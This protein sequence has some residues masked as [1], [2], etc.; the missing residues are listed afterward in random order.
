M[1]RLL[2]SALLSLTASVADAQNVHTWHTIAANTGVW[3]ARLQ[4]INEGGRFVSRSGI[5]LNQFLVS[6][7][8]SVDYGFA[9][10]KGTDFDVSYSL[11]MTKEDKKSF[12]SKACVFIITA[13]KPADPDVRVESFHGAKC[14][15]HV[16]KGVGENFT[17]G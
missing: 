7:S 10:P 1:K 13:N 16:V 15:W 9:F 12:T 3:Q 4:M 8:H 6:P 17:V 11:T 5:A 2:I 14:D